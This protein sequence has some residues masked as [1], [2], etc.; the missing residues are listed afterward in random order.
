[1]QLSWLIAKTGIKVTAGF[2]KLLVDPWVIFKTFLANLDL[3]AI[4][5]RQKCMLISK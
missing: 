3:I 1:M 4:N 2:C 5:G